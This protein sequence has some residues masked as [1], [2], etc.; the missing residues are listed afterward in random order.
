MAECRV[1][2][3]EGVLGGPKWAEHG[4][5]KRLDPNPYLEQ[6][7]KIKKVSQYI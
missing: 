5:L 1:S 6:S 2:G 4:A 7:V 3:C